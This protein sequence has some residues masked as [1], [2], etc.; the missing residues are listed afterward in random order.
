MS[1][2]P[3]LHRIELIDFSL[4]QRRQAASGAEIVGTDVRIRAQKFDFTPA[5]PVAFMAPIRLPFR[6][7]LPEPLEPIPEFGWVDACRFASRTLHCSASCWEA[8][9]LPRRNG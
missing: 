9:I 2:E 7:L 4:R 3:L 8:G 6:Q 5:P 1:D